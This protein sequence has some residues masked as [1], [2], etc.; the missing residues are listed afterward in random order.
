[1]QSHSLRSWE[2]GSGTES[3]QKKKPEGG[4]H[5]QFAAFPASFFSP[6]L[7]KELQNQNCVM[8]QKTKHDKE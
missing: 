8:T 3:V 5:L 7:A 4:S 1:M 6:D 2:P